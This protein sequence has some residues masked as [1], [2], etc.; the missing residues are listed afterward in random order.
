MCSASPNPF[1]RGYKAAFRPP[2]GKSDRAAIF[3]STNRIVREVVMTRDINQWSGQTEDDLQ[4]ALSDVNWDIQT[5][6]NCVSM[7]PSA[8]LLT[9]VLLPTTLAPLPAT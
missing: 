6:I 4:V 3:Q 8:A 2:F 5:F 1:K 9:P 7:D